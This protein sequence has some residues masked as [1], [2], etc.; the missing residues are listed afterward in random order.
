MSI[1]LQVDQH[2]RRESFRLPGGGCC[3]KIIFHGVLKATVG[4]GGGKAVKAA[5]RIDGV[6]QLD[7]GERQG[8]AIRA[9]I[10]KTGLRVKGSINDH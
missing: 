9:M 7:V 8:R 5:S 2:L 1:G 4:G 3:A 6:L 10:G